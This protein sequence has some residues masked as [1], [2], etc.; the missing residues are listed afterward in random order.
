M[1]EPEF[2]RHARRPAP[3]V[4]DPIL[5]WAIGLTTT[6]RQIYAGWMIESGKHDDLD[7]AMHNAGF[8]RVTIKHGSGAI[9][10]HWA[11][12][13]ANVFVI[14][15]GI[16]TPAEMR[17][18]A[19]RFGVAYGWRSTDAGRRQSVLKARVL[20]RELLEAGYNDPLT[21]T[22]KST[23]TGD[24]LSAFMRQYDVLNAVD[25]FRQED[26]KPVL[27]PPF[28][29]C[30]LPLVPGEEVTRGSGANTKPVIPPVA[31]VPTLIG[32]DYVRAHWIKRPW[33]A[34]IEAMIDDTIR[35]SVAESQRIAAGDEQPEYQTA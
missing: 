31:D 12:E 9:V 25:N 2:T 29:A 3:T 7:I 18:T 14:A 11:V 10:T 1:A 20:L 6:N 26:G 15:D 5:Q 30:S 27:N 33:T 23:L 24:V 28:Y 4:E 35:W 19:E 17:G 22:V 21:L 34:H 13:R 8:Q 32:R 16:Q